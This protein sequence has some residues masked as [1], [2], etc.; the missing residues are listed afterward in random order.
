MTGFDG[1]LFLQSQEC[2]N[3]DGGMPQGFSCGL[4]PVLDVPKWQML[5]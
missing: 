2:H 4:Y 1:S 5:M 3:T